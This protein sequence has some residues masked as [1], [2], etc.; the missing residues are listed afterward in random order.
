[1]K[2]R[3][4]KTDPEPLPGPD[5]LDEKGRVKPEAEAARPEAYNLLAI[6]AALSDQDIAGV[7]N[8][9]A[10]REFSAF[11][12]DLTDLA[13]AVLGPIGA[14]MKRLLAHPDE[15]DAVLAKGAQRARALSE[16][17]LKEIE[18]KVGF[19]SA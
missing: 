9:F 12:R 11:K 6:H 7:I 19:L 8:G 18:D 16:P 4:A 2:L 10:G 13:V 15:I 3:K 14:E 1:M 17:V 5:V